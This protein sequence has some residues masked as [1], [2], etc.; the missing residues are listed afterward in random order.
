MGVGFVCQEDKLTAVLEGEID[1][2]TAAGLRE[3][4]DR[5]VGQVKPGELRLDF[6]KVSFMDSSGIGLILG[7][8]RLM[9][10][11]GG[12]TVVCGLSEQMERIVALSGVERLVTIEQGSV[13]SPEPE[14]EQEPLPEAEDDSVQEDSGRD[15]YSHSNPSN[16]NVKKKKG[17]KRK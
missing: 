12:R 17:G 15:I 5:R 14:P 2:H 11:M 7:R 6:G 4:I 9:G 13:A 1:H 3:A 10:T 16:R 8:Y